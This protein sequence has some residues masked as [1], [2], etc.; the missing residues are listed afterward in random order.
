MR[1]FTILIVAIISFLCSFVALNGRTTRSTHKYRHA[2]ITLPRLEV[3]DST[4]KQNVLVTIANRIDS[5]IS[6]SKRD[7]L[8]RFYTV[9]SSKTGNSVGIYFHFYENLIS[10][11]DNL[12]GKPH[13]YMGY[14]QMG[15]HLFVIEDSEYKW[16]KNLFQRVVP[17]QTKRFAHQVIPKDEVP[18]QMD[19]AGEW[20]AEY[21]DDVY[22][23]VWGCTAWIR[24][25]V[26]EESKEKNK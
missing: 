18:P 6:C 7:S 13:E 3:V 26:G 9:G 10:H 2:K 17:A 1:K 25:I 11:E 8:N 12:K 19:F 22:N 4:F 24:Y 20:N 21:K 15:K 5:I 14:V 16:F 23:I